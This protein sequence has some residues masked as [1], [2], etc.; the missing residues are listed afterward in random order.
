MRTFRFAALLFAVSPFAFAAEVREVAVVNGARD[1]V[2]VTATDPLPAKIEG[3]VTVVG[4]AA[5]KFSL[6]PPPVQTLVVNG[7]SLPIV[8]Q[9]V[10]A[11]PPITGTVQ[12]APSNLV[13]LSAFGSATTP[14]QDAVGQNALWFTCTSNPSLNNAQGIFAVPKGLTLSIESGFLQ[15]ALLNNSFS[16]VSNVQLVDFPLSGANLIFLPL[17]LAA[18]SSSAPSIELAR[19]GPL[20]AYIPSGDSLQFSYQFRAGDQQSTAE[21]ILYGSLIATSSTSPAQ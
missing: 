6:P 11:L 8:T 15:I 1:P 4:P 19:S 5:S 18:A 14:S 7:A 21:A 2:P 17:A 20:K 9:I 12:I 3:T 10:G 16:Y 13:T